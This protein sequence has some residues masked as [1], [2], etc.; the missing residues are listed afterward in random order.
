MIFATVGAQM[1]FDRMIR[2]VDSWAGMRERQ[3]VFAQI[4]P[5]KY[6]PRHIR[7]SRFIN[8]EQFRDSVR[9]ADVIVSHAGMGTIISAVEMRKPILVM[10][11]RGNL[12]ETRNDH[13][14]ATAEQL[15]AM[16]LVEVAMDEE[17][18]LAKLD[19]LDRLTKTQLAG[20]KTSSHHCV[21]CPFGEGGCPAGAV[22]AACP[23]LL[24]A[25]HAFIA[26][27]RPVPARDLSLPGCLAPGACGTE[28]SCLCAVSSGA[29]IP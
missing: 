26:D 15:N 8:P 28:P 12:G 5:S 7:Y 10:P 27:E 24:A 14:V 2:I 20:R 3:D 23:H 22:N 18:L 16:R 13:Q 21:M 4:G 1:P 11:R 19:T 29:P 17:T 6:R 25:I 9:S